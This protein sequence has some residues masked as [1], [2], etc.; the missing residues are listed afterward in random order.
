MLMLPGSGV[1]L[2]GGVVSAAVC[3][4]TMYE[5]TA[6]PAP[7]LLL[8]PGSKLYAPAELKS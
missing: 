7:K 6:E 2:T 4:Q 8:K 3:P 1:E 5:P